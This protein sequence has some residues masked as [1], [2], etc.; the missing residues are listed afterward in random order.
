MKASPIGVVGVGPLGRCFVDRLRGGDHE[1]VAFDIDSQALAEACAAGARAADSP[2]EVASQCPVVI[3]CVTGPPEVLECALGD[4][5][6]VASVHE[7][8]LI[9][10]TTTS[11]PETTQRV[12]DV[13]GKRGVSV[14]DAPVSRGLPAAHQGTLSIMVGGAEADL[15]R[16]KPVLDLLGTDIIRVGPVGTG[17]A[18]KLINMMLMGAHLVALSEAVGVGASVGWSAA[19]VVAKL[20]WGN[21]ASF[22]TTN[23]LPRYVVAGSYQSGFTLGLM[24]KD[25]QLAFDMGTALGVHQPVL[26]RVVE[27]YKRA[28]EGLADQSDNMLIVPFIGALASG[29]EVA[30]ALDA[31]IAMRLPVKETTSVRNVDLDDLGELVAN[32]NRQACLEAFCTMIATGVD[33]EAALSVIDVSSGASYYT[34]QLLKAVG[35]N[36]M[37]SEMN[38]ARDHHDG[39]PWSVLDVATNSD[40]S[41]RAK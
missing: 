6:L 13:L 7:G 15:H 27:A 38:G 10:E 24:A 22:M 11:L 36:G 29:R 19:D 2:A 21:T 25:L 3:V 20:N 37:F 33:V 18:V 41:R 30:D 1:V 14:I 8:C 31:A 32:S 16:A 5:G 28:R 4:N 39:R 40:A 35:Y 17:H 34:H 12:A 26:W 9:I 23:H